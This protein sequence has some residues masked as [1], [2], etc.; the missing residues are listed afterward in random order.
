MICWIKTLLL[1]T[2]KEGLSGGDSLGKEHF[3]ERRGVLKA[4]MMEQKE[5]ANVGD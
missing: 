1:G 4:Q 3:W 2:Q 5:E